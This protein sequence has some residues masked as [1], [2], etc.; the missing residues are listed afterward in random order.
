MVSFQL[1]N[2]KM[3][4]ESIN[5]MTYDCYPNFAYSLDLY[6][7]DETDLKDRKWSRRLTEVRSISPVFR[8]MEQQSGANGWNSRIEAPSPRP[9]QITLWTMQSI[10]HGADFV[11]Y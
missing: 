8:I 3:T 10:A 4:N 5:F 2:H 6:S 7:N 9:G 1:D 11:N